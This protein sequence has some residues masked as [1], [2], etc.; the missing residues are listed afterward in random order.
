[1]IQRVSEAK[2]EIEGKV[3]GEIGM[4]LLLLLGIEKEDSSEDIHW[5]CNKLISLRIFNDNDNKMNLSIKDIGGDFLI[6]SQFTLHASCKKGNRPSFIRA[7]NPDVAIPLYDEFIKVLKHLSGLKVETGEFGAMMNV[8]LINSGPVT[9]IID[10][11][12]KE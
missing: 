12:N 6:I 1:M 5:L 10:S 3:S 11:K 8:S 2:V 9:I 7:A 4:G